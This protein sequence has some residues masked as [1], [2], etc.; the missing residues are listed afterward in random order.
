MGTNALQEMEVLTNLSRIQFTLPSL[1][2]FSV[3]SMV[4]KLD[5]KSPVQNHARTHL[6]RTQ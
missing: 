3:M 2:M 1:S 5:F 4:K 6:Q